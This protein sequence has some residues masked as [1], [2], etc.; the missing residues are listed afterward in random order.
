MLLIYVE[1]LSLVKYVIYYGNSYA[2]K[3]KIIIKSQ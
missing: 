1:I 3:K 2:M